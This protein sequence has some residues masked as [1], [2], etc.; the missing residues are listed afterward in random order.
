MRIPW[1][2][3]FPER[4]INALPR[5]AGLWQ[6]PGMP[7]A[8]IGLGS[9]LGDR[10]AALEAAFASMARIPGVSDAVLSPVYETEPLGPPQPSYLNACARLRVEGMTPQA[11]LQ[12]L[13]EEEL[14]QGRLR[15]E[16]WGPRT[17][18]L[19]LLLWDDLVSES[20]GLSLPHPRLHQ[21]AFVLRPLSDLDPLLRHPV[22]GRTV[23][24]LLDSLEHADR[25]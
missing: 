6:N 21:R 10:A 24:E 17:L 4:R 13:Q 22:L 23:V 9:N 20:P 15:A 25:V 19:D 1:M 8:W 7:L 11:L 3:G 12:A 14:R 5:A 2:I 18:D 16:R